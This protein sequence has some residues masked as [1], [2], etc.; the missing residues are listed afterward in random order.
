V[1]PASHNVESIR[2]AAGTRGVVFIPTKIDFLPGFVE[3]SSS[4]QLSFRDILNF[5]EIS[6]RGRKNV[7]QILIELQIVYFDIFHPTPPSFLH[8]CRATA[9]DTHHALPDAHCTS[10]ET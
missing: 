8:H 6:L 7:F 4:F 1:T 10:A 5:E 3:R 9:W 2:S